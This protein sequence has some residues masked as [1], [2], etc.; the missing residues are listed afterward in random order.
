MSTENWLETVIDVQKMIEDQQFDRAINFYHEE[1]E[2]YN[3]QH[4]VLLENFEAMKAIQWDK[5][6]YDGD[7]LVRSGN[8]DTWNFECGGHNK[9]NKVLDTWNFECGGHNK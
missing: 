9:D 5:P 8:L 6:Y 2:N 7:V 1:F 3:E 4:D